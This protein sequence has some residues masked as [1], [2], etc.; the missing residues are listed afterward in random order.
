MKHDVIALRA[1]RLGDKRSPSERIELKRIVM[2]TLIVLLISGCGSKTNERPAVYPVSGKVVSK[3]KSLG[4]AMLLFHPLRHD[5]K[6]IR[7]YATT[8]IDGSFE[9]STFEAYDGAPEGDYAVTITWPTVS[10][11]DGGYGE[12]RLRGQFNNP[13]TTPFRA[14]ITQSDTQ[15]PTFEI[16]Q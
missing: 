7:S 9:V 15:L 8:E 1:I 11:E 14:T 2:A 6:E 12:D 3:G 4:G 16:P 5:L 10:V 13:Q